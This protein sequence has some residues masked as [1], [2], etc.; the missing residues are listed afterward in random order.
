MTKPVPMHYRG[1]AKYK[2]R[3]YVRTVLAGWAVCCSGDKA[4]A[5]RANGNHTYDRAKVT[6]TKCLSVLEKSDAYAATA[7][8]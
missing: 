3:G 8:R 7:T 6:C 1:E 4:Y 5:V 2:I